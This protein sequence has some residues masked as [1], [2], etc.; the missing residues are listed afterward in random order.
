MHVCQN[1]RLLDWN[2]QGRTSLVLLI[3]LFKTKMERG[4]V[5]NGFLWRRGGK[6]KMG[7]KGKVQRKQD[8]LRDGL[9]KNKELQGIPID[10]KVFMLG[11]HAYPKPQI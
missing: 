9:A 6:G 1:Y 8:T 4:I 3:L 2:K 10:R 7:D 5:Q 11:H